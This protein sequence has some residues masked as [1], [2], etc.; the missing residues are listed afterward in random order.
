MENWEALYQRA[1][2]IAVKA[3][4]GQ[5]DKGGHPYIAHPL[6]VASK[7][8]GKNEKIAALLHDVVEDSEITLNELQKEFP[9]D[10]VTAVDLLTKKQIPD[11][12]QQTYLEK[13]KANAIAR[14]VKLADL[15]HNM[16]I[17]RIPDP[18]EQD[19]VRTQRYRASMEF[20]MD[21]MD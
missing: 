6:A 5:L 13:I 8:E 16:D 10:I 1:L 7:V 12:S 9:E 11:F 20:L 18:K 15:E 14:C 4:E 17:S 21:S 19:Y 3:H 2:D